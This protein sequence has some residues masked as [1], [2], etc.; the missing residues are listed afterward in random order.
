MSEKWLAIVNPVSGGNRQQRMSQRIVNC[1]LDQA[2][3]IDVRITEER[4]SAIGIAEDAI[5]QGIRNIA[6]I[7]G[8]GTL[9]EVVNGVFRQQAVKT[10]DVTLAMFS[11]G[12]GNDF[13]RTMQIPRN[14]KDA[15][16]AMLQG[17]TRIID[18]GR[19]RYGATDKEQVRYFVNVCG[20]A[21]DGAVTE[22]ANSTKG[23]IGRMAYLRSVLITLF[24]YEPTKV[25]VTV[26]G[27]E[28]ADEL[29]F[30]I[31]VGNCKYSGGGMRLVPEAVPDDGLFDITL[32]R[33][34]PKLKVLM[35]LYRLFDGSIYRIKEA[36]HLRG[37]RIT[38]FS[39]PPIC[40]EAEGEFI[41]YS[42]FELEIVPAAIR[43]I[44]P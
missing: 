1:L 37:K 35:N 16:R 5:E 13:I 6:V 31:N 42:P 7:G 19:L 20:M 27:K 2:V 21:F 4:G 23:S 30:C 28:V 22:H 29:L 18:A 41:G 8:D 25:R 36:T 39:D 15:A 44:V 11:L 17:K 43:I 34:L 40:A 26:D 38:V 33:P 10:T 24:K 14:Y 9:N 32:L 12:T 3:D